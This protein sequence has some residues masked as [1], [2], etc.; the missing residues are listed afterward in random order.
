[1]DGFDL[2]FYRQAIW[3]TGQ[4]HF[5]TVSGTD[6]SPSLLGT[7][8]IL[9]YALL[10][11]FYWL[12]PSAMTLLVLE[13]LVVAA[14]A[15]PVYWLA[16]DR[17]KNRWWALSLAA[18]YL[19]LPAV[20]NGNLYELRERML[21]GSFLLFA[22]YWWQKGRLGW[23]AIAAIL[24]LCCRPENGLVL[25][26]LGVYGWLEDRHRLAEK[27]GW[28]YIAGPVI[29]G[30]VW[31]GLALVIISQVSRGGYALGST[32]AG[33]SPVA[34][35]TTLFTN[36]GLGFQQLF[37]TGSALWGK[38]LYIPF[39]LLPFGF[40]P[41]FQPRL[42]LITLPPV[43]LNLLAG[44]RR[45]LQWNAFDYHYQAAVMPWLMVATIFAIERLI[46]KPPGWLAWVR[47]SQLVGLVLTLTLAINLATNLMSIASLDLSKAGVP[48]V[49]NGWAKILTAKTEPR[50]ESGRALLKMVPETGSLA[51]SNVWANEVAP[52][53]GLWYFAERP[54]YSIH[55]AQD[56]QY[57]F[58]DLHSDDPQLIQKVMASGDWQEIGRQNDY[59]LLKRIR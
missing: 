42:L 5:L 14:G 29:L 6:F 24:A 10:A 8:V 32:F 37:P 3:N 13:T 28:R 35:I 15:I 59:L 57:I 52:R 49:K 39:L 51:I 20:Q 38:L 21:G 50:W 36:P 12:I 2:A 25:I 31:L 41:L 22:F 47:G 43:G 34:A 7:D 4:G 11:P 1:M 56:A 58:S 44:N 33:G 46:R 23:F 40:L 53:S 45:D 27:A 55:P 48:P 9:I 18:T 26:M 17:L 54:L 16:R 19:L 30:A